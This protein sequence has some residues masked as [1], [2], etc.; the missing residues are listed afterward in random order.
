[1][2]LEFNM[3]SYLGDKTWYFKYCVASQFT[4]S[5][6]SVGHLVSQVYRCVSCVLNYKIY[7]LVSHEI[8]WLQII[9][10]LSRGAELDFRPFLFKVL[11]LWNYSK[12]SPPLVP[13]FGQKVFILSIRSEQFTLPSHDLT[14]LSE[15]LIIFFRHCMKSFV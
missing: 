11:L 15:E 5:T 8:L 12:S 10:I 2:V 3:R 13:L 4:R 1:M 14:I 7:G 6:Q 9:K